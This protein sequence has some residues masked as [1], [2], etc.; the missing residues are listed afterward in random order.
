[1]ERWAEAETRLYDALAVAMPRARSMAH[2]WLCA[3]FHVARRLPEAQRHAETS[4]AIA[5]EMGDGAVQ[6]LATAHLAALSAAAGDLD[7]A[8]ALFSAARGHAIC[9]DAQTIAA[10]VEVATSF[11]DLSD[12]D[13]PSLQITGD[14]VLEIGPDGLWI[15]PP[16]SARFDMSRRRA[17]RLVLLALADAR[18]RTPGLPLGRPEILEA[19]WPGEKMR[20][21]AGEQRVRTAIWTLRKLGVGASLVTRGDG[22]LLDPAVR[23]VRASE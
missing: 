12:A 18:E 7:G 10:L 16:G 9:N 4:L 13:D 3:M 5:S 14:A 1:M 19:G 6:A 17:V 23:I 22:Y 11:L 15:R 20:F 21:A 2:L 8:R